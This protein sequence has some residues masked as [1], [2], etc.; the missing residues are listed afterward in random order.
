MSTPELGFV[1]VAVNY[2]EGTGSV[3]KTISYCTACNGNSQYFV[4]QPASNADTQCVSGCFTSDQQYGY[5]TTTIGSSTYKYCAACDGMYF[6]SAPE[7]NPGHQQEYECVSTCSTRIFQESVVSG[8]D[9]V[10][11]Y[12]VSTC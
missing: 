9:T 2:T 8:S 12:C 10:L 4:S 3:E 1:R 7:L 11:K 5:K 6:K